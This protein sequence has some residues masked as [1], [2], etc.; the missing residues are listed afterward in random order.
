DGPRLWRMLDPIRRHLNILR[1]DGPT[2]NER[3]DALDYDALMV[4]AD[5][6]AGKDGELAFTDLLDLG[7]FPQLDTPLPAPT[8]T[9]T[10]A[11][12]PTTPGATTPGAPN[13][14]PARPPLPPPAPRPLP[15]LP[16]RRRPTYARRPRYPSQEA[17]Q[18]AGRQPAR[19]MIRI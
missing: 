12:L 6:A 15:P 8:S 9:P 13:R 4:I 11:G 14:S 10:P 5:I 3:L 17:S 2:P 16:R 18:E 7:L 1:R 19:V